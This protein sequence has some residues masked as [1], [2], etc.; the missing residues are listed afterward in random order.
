MS[1]RSLAELEAGLPVIRRSPADQGR[2]ER[3][4]RRPDFGEREVLSEGF[5]DL[6]AGL[7]G[8]GW[9]VR[10]SRRTP[11]GSPHPEM[12][13]NVMSSRVAAL[14]AGGNTGWEGAGDQLYVDLDLSPGNVPAGTRLVIGAAVIEIT[15]QPH[16]G[17]PKFAARFGEEALRFVNSP[18]GRALQLRGVNAKVVAAGA[19]RVG[20]T[21]TVERPPRT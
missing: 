3:I 14:I 11:D 7:V 1:Y 21:V 8:D 20:D 2:L 6:A 16:R 13:V 10:P 17:C 18:V 15:A 4:A 5:L 12:Q 9:L 19:V